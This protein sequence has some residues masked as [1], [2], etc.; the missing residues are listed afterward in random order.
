MNI[1]FQD[2]IIY[3]VVSLAILYLIFPTLKSVFFLLFKPKS[4]QNRK[5]SSYS[6]ACAKCSIRK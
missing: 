4:M 2:K 6:E 5:L 3:F 1:E